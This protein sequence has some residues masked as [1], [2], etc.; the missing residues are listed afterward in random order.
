MPEND[1]EVRKKRRH[2]NERIAAAV[3]V[4][5]LAAGVAAFVRWNAR[6]QALL[7]QQTYVPKRQVITPEILLLRDYVRIDTST[8]A[9]VAAGA[10]WLA[11]QLARAGIRAELIPSAE[12]RVNV[13]ARIAGR[14]R[15]GGLL[16]F[17]HI[18]VFP[19]AGQQWSRPPFAGEM[20][21]N[22]LYGRGTVD[23]KALA[24]CQLLAFAAVARSGA[25]PEHDLVF[26]AT[27][28]EETGSEYGMQWLLAHRPDIFEGIGYGITEGGIT[29]VLSERVTY[30]G[31]EVGSKQYSEVELSAPTV[32]AMR[33]A[34]FAL[35]P[36]LVQREA[37]RVLPS[38]RQMFHDMAATRVQFRPLLIDID[39][40][41]A[42]GAFWQLP[43]PYRDLTQNS[44]LV[45]A[46][47]QRD[48]GAT[49]RVRLINLPDED[50]DARIA[51]LAETV[52]PAGARVARVVRKE[53]RVPLS[54]DDTP[55]FRLLAAEATRRYRAPAGVEVLYR[56]GSDARF[57]RPRGIV[58][59][60]VSPYR[61][62]LFQ[63]LAIHKADERI[64]L[65]FFGEGVDYLRTV[66][67]QWARGR[68]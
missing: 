56:S 45:D 38:V 40:T 57:L 50:P 32:E 27:A 4:V 29:E 19:V 15:G 63:S 60:G 46:P 9:G 41:I 64:R 6:E 20:Q 54:R 48:G 17:N 3:L 13:Y 22:M 14:Q 25:A 11:A 51:W 1:A 47:L 68:T 8:P 7:E 21:L 35:E 30:F 65:D 28:D 49:M 37:T 43:I 16:L 55:L 18:D 33:A 5:A 10:R 59:Y 52:R 34:R 66:V 23:M 31:I 61:V 44:M 62:D 42:R 12:G 58:C 67:E 39:A 24:I 53:P 2:R 26:L 36:W